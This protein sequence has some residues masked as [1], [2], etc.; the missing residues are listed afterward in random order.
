MKDKAPF[1][2]KRKL[3]VKKYHVIEVNTK[4]VLASYNAHIVSSYT[5]TGRES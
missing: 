3:I 2:A 1:D 5:Q 4:Q